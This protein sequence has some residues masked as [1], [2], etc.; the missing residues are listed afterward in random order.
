MKNNA[1]QKNRIA[2]TKVNREGV[3]VKKENINNK[4]N[5]VTIGD[6]TLTLKLKGFRSY[7]N[8]SC[9]LPLYQSSHIRG[10]NGS[11]KS[12]LY[13]AIRWALFSKK[14]DKVHPID[15][16]GQK[17]SVRLMFQMKEG[18]SIILRTACP[19]YL[20]FKHLGKKYEN[21]DAETMIHSVF[22]SRKKWDLCSHIEE[23]VHSFISASAPM[24][25][26]M[27][28]DLIGNTEEAKKKASAIVLETKAELN[29]IERYHDKLL[30][31]FD[32][33]F[34]KPYRI[35]DTEEIK[36]DESLII[37]VKKK[38]E[39][40]NEIVKLKELHIQYQKQI[41]ELAV[42][43]SKEKTLIK[44]ITLHSKYDRK[45]LEQM[46]KDK[47]LT[48]AFKLVETKL[49]KAKNALPNNN[50]INDIEFI[51]KDYDDCIVNTRIYDDNSK[52]CRDLKISY[53]PKIIKQR[54]ESLNQSITEF[55]S[56][57]ELFKQEQIYE[58]AKNKLIVNFKKEGLSNLINSIY[59]GDINKV[60][61]D[62]SNMIDSIKTSVTRI[63]YYLSYCF[64]FKQQDELK[65]VEVELT[66]TKAE[67]KK[68]NSESDKLKSELILSNSELDRIKLE[69][70][71]IFNKLKK[72]SSNEDNFDAKN[73]DSDK[74]VDKLTSLI[75]KQHIFY[76][77]EEYENIYESYYE[78]ERDENGDI[79]EAVEFVHQR[80]SEIEG[81]LQDI[82]RSKQAKHCPHCDGLLT[83]RADG[84]IEKYTGVI[85][86]GS[87]S[88]L[89]EELRVLKKLISKKYPRVPKGLKKV[90]IKAVQECVSLA[91][92]FAK[93]RDKIS[94]QHDK[95]ST[96]NDRVL[97]QQDKVSKIEDKV[98][99]LEDKIAKLSSEITSIPSDV[100]KVNEV[101]K[102]KELVDL[103]KNAERF[104]NCL[105]LLDN[106]KSIEKPILPKNVKQINVN[107]VK[108]ELIK[109]SSII[110]ID[111]PLYTSQYIKLVMTYKEV[112]KEYDKTIR[113]SR[114]ITE[115]DVAKYL[116]KVSLLESAERDLENIQREKN[117][118]TVTQE[119]IDET[120]VDIADIEKRLTAN[121]HQ[122][123]I[124]SA[125]LKLN[126]AKE[127]MDEKRDNYDNAIEIRDII[128]S[129][130]K[131]CISNTLRNLQTN[132]NLF[133]QSMESMIRVTLFGDDKIKIT[134]SKG[135]VE[136]GPPSELSRGEGALVC[137]SMAI[138]FAL[139]SRS[140]LIIF[141]E[142]TDKLSPEWRD[143]CIET[144]LAIMKKA[145][146]TLLLTDHNSHSDDYDNILELPLKKK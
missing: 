94:S 121:T 51:Q 119:L 9:T 109:L 8:G 65:I 36:A 128:E 130:T 72:S 76:E 83:S 77:R 4:D 47:D 118:Y 125:L 105:H 41:Q 102:R 26:E 66:T 134:C 122:R 7:E 52:I 57:A 112:K 59:S 24:K 37:S 15:S 115:D 27:L 60:N 49:N 101:Q 138:A 5:V 85:V 1:D 116:V 23:N 34:R 107:E 103:R 106:F 48:T 74:Y 33:V 45:E 136:Y 113:P 20:M 111:K 70:D 92:K 11:G 42:L 38:Q 58:D 124:R 67:L 40:E 140:H 126:K 142:I 73:F 55:M 123:K 22:G 43:E 133:L 97:F 17:V 10:P 87:V 84:S 104:T 135:M 89:E 53:D 16:P 88:E 141:D 6:E 2:N 21:E 100:V 39:L 68:A 18:L 78:I 32:A 145:K 96:Q 63:E 54:I 146:K 12:D 71:E 139:E 98:S 114:M 50:K 144:L 82:K 35:K 110:Y 69:S 31:E 61:F 129:D 80:S 120:A 13:K 29:D 143:K 108:N 64:A 14:N 62:L 46:I 95:I 93:S 30:I 90:D 75:S 79:N 127:E 132:A 19:G 91:V 28:N 131:K 44:T 81:Q 3:I 117:E 86:E 99:K 25:L 137:F 56:Y